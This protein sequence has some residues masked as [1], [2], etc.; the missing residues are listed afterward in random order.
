[1]Q[2]KTKSRLKFTIAS[3]LIVIFA[4]ILSNGLIIGD[5]QIKSLGSITKLGLDLK[6]GVYIE[7]EIKGE[8]ISKDTIDR[9]KELIELRVNALGVNESVVT[10]TQ[11]NRIRIEIPGVYDAEN[12]LKQI[13]KTG[14]LT[15]RGPNND[16]VITGED[17][18]DASVGVNQQTN[19]PVVQLKLNESGTK[20]F[21]EATAKYQGKVISIYMDEE[22]VSAPVVKSVITTGE[23]II[24][25]SKDIEEA[26]RLAGIIKSGALPVELVPATV[27]TIGPSLGAD[28]IPT[29]KKAAVI[30]ITLVMLFMAIYYRIPGIIA[31]LALAVYIMLTM[32]IFTT[33]LKATLTLPGIAGLLLSVGMAVDANVLIFERIKE[34]LKLGKSLRSAVDAGFNRALPSILDS[35]ITTIIAGLV[36]MWLGAGQ[37]KGFALTLVT[38]VV[39]SLFTAV[40]VTKFL[41]KNFVNS[42]WIENKKM[43]GA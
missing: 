31:D 2:L 4:Y 20:K 42:N 21:A 28:A 13:G 5:Y 15:F 33:A 39:C 17:I 9:T 29:S 27:K 40:T 19:Q 24:E 30:G 23:A 36:L 43:Y 7:E 18:K 16:I 1:M 10:V 25:G 41:L 35:N 8:N 11:Q 12:A 3:L 32:L 14:K 34:E 37:V 26:K 22:L 38:G 6:G